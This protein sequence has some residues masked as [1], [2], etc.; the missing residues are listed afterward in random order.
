MIKLTGRA[1]APPPEALKDEMTMRTFIAVPLPKPCQE[2]LERLQLN[3]RPLG[4]DLRMV[5]VS[6]IH[7][8]LKFLGE[9]DPKALPDL[10]KAL[11]AFVSLE[12][13][14]SLCLRGVGAFPNLRNPRVIWC[15]VEG[16]T[17]K[18]ARLQE[19]VENACC[20]LGFER[21]E[22]PFRPHLTIARV[23]NKRNLQGLLDDTKIGSEL[24]S[25][26]FADHINIYRSTLAPRGAIYD[27]L[28][29][30]PLKK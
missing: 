28:A 7:L 21:E 20:D 14:L 29:T 17:E 4:A 8:T 10:S 27:I 1:G 25:E 26:F 22:R 15:G 16:D 6:S 5:A 30:I 3:F 23:N 18:L 19:K 12:P 9:I 24:Q 11:T 13:T 2:M